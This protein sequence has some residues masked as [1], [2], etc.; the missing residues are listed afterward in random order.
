[1]EQNRLQCKRRAEMGPT[2]YKPD[3]NDHREDQVIDKPAWFP[4]PHGVGEEPSKRAGW[5]FAKIL[6]L[7]GKCGLH[8]SGLPL[9]KRGGWH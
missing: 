5:R 7:S 9:P 4:K 1:M 3:H 6:R 2:R 8:R